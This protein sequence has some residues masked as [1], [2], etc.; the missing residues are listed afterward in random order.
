MIDLTQNYI[1]PL[2]F[3][4]GLL[5]GTVDA[6]MGGGGL[7]TLPVLLGVGIPPHLALGTNKFQ[8]SFGTS[9]ATWRYYR[10]GWLSFK[11][12]VLGMLPVLSG[13]SL[14]ALLSQY[15]SSVILSK[16]M[17][18]LLILILIY[19]LFSPKLGIEERHPKV[20]EITFY[21]VMGLLL[22]FYDGFFGPGTGSLWMFALVFF[23]GY[24]LPKATAYTK[25]CN[26]YSNLAALLWFAIGH[27]VDYRIG[28]VMAMG[29]MLGGWLGAHLAI[30]K[31][32]VIIRPLFISVVTATIV[33]LVYH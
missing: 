19:T 14:G 21:S 18:V 4:A 11:I 13:A 23:L 33:M 32:A 6:I 30:H 3:G 26:L 31:G 5:A 7:I 15:L 9:I 2:L 8:A 10:Q 17:P 1:L 20:R 22:G 28:L 27:Q 25:I 16:L 12:M 29:Q 24:S